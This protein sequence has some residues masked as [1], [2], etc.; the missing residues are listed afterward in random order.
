M[1]KNIVAGNW[2]MNTT[3]PEGVKLAKEVNDAVAAAGKLKCEV[4][5][6]VPF[7]H[8]TAVRQVI[9]ISKVGLAAENC[10]AQASGAYTG[11]VSASMVA[12]TGANYVILGHSERR[13]YFK[14]TP[15]MLKE[16]VDLALANGLK[17][18][19]CCGESLELRENGT[20]EDYIKCEIS[21]SLFH[22]SPEAFKNIVIAY[23]PIWAIGT[24]KTA[25][26][27]QAEEV[28]AS[29]RALVAEQ[30]GQKAADDTTILYGG[31][32]K[33]ANAPELFAKPNIDGGLIGGA[34]LKADSFMGIVMA[35]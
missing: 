6:G 11:E 24:G 13:D 16:K 35:F 32:C 12:S 3:V 2:K 27:D 1:R 9:D 28:H 25:T 26:S 29:I 21:D 5:I 17:V 18:I 7:T 14:E 10:A 20:Y 15:E 34:S 4:V 8:L 31:S 22:L 23:E 19:F 33:P 30:Y